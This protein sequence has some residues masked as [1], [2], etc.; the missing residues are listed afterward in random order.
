MLGLIW[1]VFTWL[2]SFSRSRYDLGREIVAL[3]QRS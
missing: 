2:R 3:S 1:G